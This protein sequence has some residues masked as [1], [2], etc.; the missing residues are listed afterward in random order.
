MTA[1]SSPGAGSASRFPI[2]ALR[3]G[4]RHERSLRPAADGPCPGRERRCAGRLRRARISGV[5][6]LGG[7][8]PCAT[9]CMRWSETRA[10]THPVFDGAHGSVL[11]RRQR[12][13]AC[14]E[15][16]G[17][18]GRA[19]PIPSARRSGR[20]RRAGADG[21]GFRAALSADRRPGELRQPRWRRRGGHALYRGSTRAD[22]APAARRDRRGHGRL[23]VQLRWFDRGAAP[24]AGAAALRAAQRGQRDRGRSGHRDPEP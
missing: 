7:Q 18:G 3:L 21:P 5:R 22:R 6:G 23:P 11:R 10:T 2:Q 20:L 12:R 15:C 13:E 24:A 8:G 9:R 16:P 1:R 19:G 17:R 4:T 14:Q